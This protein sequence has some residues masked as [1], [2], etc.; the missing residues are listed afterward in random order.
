LQTI[1]SVKSRLT[2]LAAL[3]AILLLVGGTALLSRPR[4]RSSP[5]AT[6]ESEA[7]QPIRPARS[8]TARTRQ[9]PPSFQPS[10]QR[11]SLSWSSPGLCEDGGDSRARAAARQELLRTFRRDEVGGLLI[12]HDPEVPPAALQT[13][14]FAIGRT[15][16]FANWLLGWSPQQFPPP[17]NVYRSAEQL[18]SVACVNLSSVAYY[19]GSIHLSGDARFTATTIQQQAAHEY[20]H[21]VLTAMGVSRPAWLHE[22]LAMQIAEETWFRKPSMG[23]VERLARE[24]LPFDALVDLMPHAARD[25]QQADLAFYQSYLMVGLLRQRLGSSGIRELLDDLAWGR[26]SPEQAF[27]RGLAPSARIEDEWR[28]FVLEHPGG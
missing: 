6:E 4:S 21:H 7:P 5:A 26:L 9:V 23:L 14:A 18:R 28:R 3:L 13:I 16:Q 11:G 8:A 25:D 15:R 22:G 12:A 10:V 27:T 1:A 24:H 2:V 19:D 20:V 17:I